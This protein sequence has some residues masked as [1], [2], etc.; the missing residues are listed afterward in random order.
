YPS[1]EDNN[2]MAHKGS[3]LTSQDVVPSETSNRSLGM[4]RCAC[5]SNYKFSMKIWMPSFKRAKSKRDKLS[6]VHL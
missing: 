3:S 1:T 4:S 6:Q 2:S 5:G